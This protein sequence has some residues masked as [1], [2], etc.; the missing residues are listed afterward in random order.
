MRTVPHKLYISPT[1]REI[2][3]RF[4]EIG[5]NKP[6]SYDLVRDIANAISH[7]QYGGRVADCFTNVRDWVRPSEYSSLHEYESAV[8]Y[9]ENVQKFIKSLDFDIFSG[10]TPLAKAAS[11]VAALS[12]QEGGQGDEGEEGENNFL[13]FFLDSSKSMEEKAKKLE[14]DVRK[15][16]QANKSLAKYIINP[17]DTSP[18]T[19]LANLTEEQKDLIEK[20][21]ILGERG[22][23]RARRTSPKNTL[24]QMS[25]Y[26]QV[27]RVNSVSEL[28]MPL[29]GYKFA[30]KQ[31]IVREPEQSTK[32]TLV[33]MIDDSGSMD[34]PEKLAWVRAL[35]INRCD[36]VARGEAELYIGFFLNTFDNENVTKIATKK[37]AL[38]YIK[39]PYKGKTSGGTNIEYAVRQVCECIKRGKIGPHR[40]KSVN[41]QIVVI[42]DGE[43]TV[44]GNFKPEIVTHGFILGQDNE[45]MKSM[46]ANCGGHYERFM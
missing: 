9:H 22:A 32:Q 44:D 45:G 30:T 20:L 26:S 2:Q 15:I 31:L 27:A 43:D 25:D 46:I 28:V 40:I 24:V 14:D 7:I 6:Y 5:F 36:A 8:S 18:E 3:K 37:D 35:I 29:F 16:V 4:E 10:N 33:L 38:E 11:I 19:G 23:I 1:R 17:N 21:A 34:T 39:S 41:P 42:N 13:P 12:S